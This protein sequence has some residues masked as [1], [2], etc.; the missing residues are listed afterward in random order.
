MEPLVVAVAANRLAPVQVAAWGHPVTTGLSTIDYF[1]SS[2]LAEPARAQ[3]HY[4]ERLITLPGMGTRFPQP[5]IARAI[6]R[7]SLAVTDDQP[8]LMCSQSI[9]KWSPSFVAAVGQILKARPNAVLVYFAI[10][11]TTPPSVFAEMLKHAWGPLGIDIAR[12][13]R[14]LGEMPRDGFLSHIAVC[15]VALDTFGFSG[16]QTS[17]D[18][19]SA[20]VP[21]VTLPGAFMRGRQTAAM[22]TLI[23][24]EELIARDKAHYVELV[25]QLV[26]DVSRRTQL[27][28]KI[29]LNKSLLFSDRRAVTE[30]TQWLSILPVAPPRA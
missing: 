17:V 26:D 21:V 8:L 13:T 2:E 15:D 28:E 1:L 10:H 5:P 29:S 11:R 16:G 23:S 20:N 9:F 7:S 12:R 3:T 25:L 27:S 14:V 19:L 24:V 22:L 30:L 6:S 4:S 18:T